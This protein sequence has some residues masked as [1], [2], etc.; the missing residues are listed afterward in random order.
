MNAHDDMLVAGLFSSQKE[1]DATLDKL[2]QIGVSDADVEVGTPEPGRYRF[3]RHE[4]AE[5]GK[6]IRKG[7][8]VGAVIGA[9]ISMGFMSFVV[10][11]LSLPGLIELGLPMGVA[12]GIF[13]GGLTGLALKAMTLVPGEPRYAI[14]E[15]SHDVLMVVHAG[16]RLGATH[17]V[18]EHQHPRY[19]LTD[20]P[21]VHHGQ[22]DLVA[23]A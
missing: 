11:G 20:V 13:F 23:S 8:F 14:T 1:V 18:I 9:L 19:L 7:M 10:R 17:E 15:D 22:R 6:A 4:S 21:A 3:E 2:H 12:W 16:D 5:L